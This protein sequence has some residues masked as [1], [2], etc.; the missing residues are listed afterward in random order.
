[1]KSIPGLAVH[2]AAQTHATT[3]D[4]RMHAKHMPTDHMKLGD[5][6]KGLAS[7]KGLTV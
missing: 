6:M 7:K 3:A 2:K 1:M 5:E 4:V